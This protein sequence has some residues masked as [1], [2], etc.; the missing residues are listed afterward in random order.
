MLSPPLVSVAPAPVVAKPISMQVEEWSARL[1]PIRTSIERATGALAAEKE[2]EVALGTEVAAAKGRLE[3]R[4]AIEAF[5]EGIQ[6]D[7]HRRVT[8]AYEDLLSALARDVLGQDVRVH[9]KPGV[10]RGLACLDIEAEFEGARSSVFDGCGGSLTNLVSFGLRAIATRKS[11]MRFFLALDEA[12]CWIRPQRAAAFYRVIRDLVSRTQG[13]MQALVVSHH[14]LEVFP[15]NVT[16]VRLSKSPGGKMRSDLLASQN[17]SN[18]ETQG[19]RSLRLIDFASAED[20]TIPLGPGVTVITGENNIGKSRFMQ[21]LRAVFYGESSDGDIRH[22]AKSAQVEIVFEGG[23]T[24][25]WS[26]KPTRNPVNHWIMKDRHGVTMSSG[27]A[28]C[29]TGGRAVPGWVKAECGIARVEDMDLQISRQLTPVFLL[30]EPASRRA[31][32]LSVGR[33]SG[34]L[35]AMLENHKQTVNSDRSTVSRG[36]RDI[37]SAL[38]RIAAL[39]PLANLT[40][41]VVKLE[42]LLKQTLQASER[43][44][45]IML[46]L[47]KINASHLAHEQAQKVQ[48][49]LLDLPQELPTPAPIKPLVSLVDTITRSENDH[50]KAEAIKIALNDLPRHLPA[51]PQ[52]APLART[53]TQLSK[54]AMGLIQARAVHVALAELPADLVKPQPISPIVAVYSNLTQGEVDLSRARAVQ[55]ALGDMP[56]AMTPP[57]ALAPIKKTIIAINASFEKMTGARQKCTQVDEEVNQAREKITDLIDASDGQ[58]PTCGGHITAEGILA[59]HHGASV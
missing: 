41:D 39:Q 42:Q 13:A 55:A 21:A 12:D 52:T 16:V 29:D 10:E 43:A 51:P 54:S 3:M 40:N 59:H 5:M 32:V 31:Q 9:L 53:L 58:C 20:V 27:G 45:A 47:R 56:A 35:L 28:I 23:K 2:R 4:P 11:G 8:G 24:L 34:Y 15:A 18:D 33:E 50:R 26:R 44:R 37:A 25:S 1:A 36:E 48:N 57:S 22:G 30:D 17:W 19:I 46:L 38:K 14:A 49:T 6:G 7:I